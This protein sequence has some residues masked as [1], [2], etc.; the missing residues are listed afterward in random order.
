M[1][2]RNVKKKRKKKSEN[3]VDY[4][5]A[6]VVS[7][8]VSIESVR[9]ISSN[10][11][12]APVA[13]RGK[14]SLEIVCDVK[15]KVD[16]EKGYIFV[17]PAFQLKA[18]P[19]KKNIKEPSMVI[20]ATFLIVYKAESLDG[21]KQN[22]FEAFAQTNGVYNAWPYWRELVQNTIARMSLPPLTIPVFRL[23]KNNK[24]NLAA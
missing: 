10:C 21:L 5:L 22:N 19:L 15:T 23:V 9:L 12:Q 14:N 11:L 7:D 13:G 1:T 8:R 3:T 16:K 24:K 20:E 4:R 17:F 6:V 18:F 2:K